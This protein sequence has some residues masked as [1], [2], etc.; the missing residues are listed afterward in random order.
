MRLHH[1]ALRTRDLEALAGFYRD[2]FGLP[3]VR[4][5]PGYS[6]WLRAG[7]VVLMLERRG[8]EEP[9][10]AEGSQDLVAF[11]V[12]PEGREEV[13]A[14]LARRGV[15]VEAST[16]HTRYFRDPDGRRVA[17]ST[18]PLEGGVIAR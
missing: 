5:T 9:G 14:R 1:L 13:L 11:A 16:E 7:D 12:D 6:V 4:E 2:V 3:A 8:E 10:P 18:H 15:P 17:V